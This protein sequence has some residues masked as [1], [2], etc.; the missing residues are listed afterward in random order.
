MAIPKEEAEFYV[1]KYME[2]Q[3][4]LRNSGALNQVTNPDAQTYYSTNYISFVFEKYR[5]DALFANNPEA[6]ALRIYY[7]AHENGDPTIVLVAAQMNVENRL[8]MN[9]KGSGPRDQWPGWRGTRTGTGIT[10]F[11]IDD[12]S[13]Y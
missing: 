9:S 12:D 5:V 2:L 8:V 4:S 7:G 6:D 3:D 10:D 11:D 1:K 13:I